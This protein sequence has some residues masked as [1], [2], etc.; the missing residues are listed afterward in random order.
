[1]REPERYQRWIRKDW[2]ELVDGLRLTDLQKHALRSRW[3]DRVLWT[4]RHA[5]QARRAYYTLRPAPT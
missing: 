5:T 4:E 1:M 3:I 2:Q